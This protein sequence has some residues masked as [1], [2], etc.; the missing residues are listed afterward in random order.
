MKFLEWWLGDR[1]DPYTWLTLLLIVV[2]IALPTGPEWFVAFLLLVG[3]TVVRRVCPWPGRT[4][5]KGR[6]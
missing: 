1:R 3:T 6:E 5:V 4:T 2:I